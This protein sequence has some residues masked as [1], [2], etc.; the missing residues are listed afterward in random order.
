MASHK[1]NRNIFWAFLDYVE[2]IYLYTILMLWF[3]EKN[4]VVYKFN[5]V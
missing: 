4:I 3:V 2:K 1:F 5:V